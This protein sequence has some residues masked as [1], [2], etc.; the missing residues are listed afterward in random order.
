VGT[1]SGLGRF[2]GV[3]WTNYYTYNSGLPDASIDDITVNALNGIKWISTDGGLA[4]FDDIDWTV[5]DHTNTPL[6][7][8]WIRC[9]TIQNNTIWVGTEYVG[10]AKFDGGSGWTIYNTSNSD[11]PSNTVRSIA[12]DYNTGHIWV[13]TYY[14]GVADFDGTNW[15]VYNKNNSGL[16]NNSVRG[17]SID[18]NGVK[19]FATGGGLVRFDGINWT[20]YNTSNSGIPDNVLNC[21]WAVDADVWVGTDG[22]GAAVLVDGVVGLQDGK[23]LV[24][25][26]YPN[27]FT[28]QVKFEFTA[29]QDQLTLLRLF[30]M[31]GREVFRKSYSF[32]ANVPS[33]ITIDG[34]NL[35]R[36]VYSYFLL[37]GNASATG[38]IIRE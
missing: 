9:A 13:G 16:P 19:W 37:S 30:D 2:D 17:I 10:M 8:D 22:E 7:D 1:V 6:T 14:G 3:N 15:I 21:V 32:K 38:K 12:V 11:I 20:V 36:G 18:N 26:V 27:P 25:S 33:Q 35:S 23:T 4:K 28:D 34:K 31:T 29:S 24:H 5:Y